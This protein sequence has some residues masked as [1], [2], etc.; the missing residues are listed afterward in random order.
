MQ[1]ANQ[2]FT[3]KTQVKLQSPIY[4]KRTALVSQIPNFWKLVLE[5]A[6][7]DIDQFIQPSDSACLAACLKSITVRNYEIDPVEVPGGDARSLEIAFEFE[8]NEYF[9]DSKIVKKFA[10]RRWRDGMV[11]FTSEPVKINWKAGKDLTHGLLD[12][13]VAAYQSGYWKNPTDKDTPHATEK[14]LLDKINS[15]GGSGSFFNFFGF[16]GRRL[17][18]AERKL[19]NEEEAKRAKGEDIPYVETEDETREEIEAECEIFPDGDDLAI[20]FAEDLWP[21]A[22]KYFTQTQQGGE[23]EDDEEL[24]EI[25]GDEDGI[26]EMDEDESEEEKPKSK[27]QKTNGKN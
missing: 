3:V 12:A 16:V 22:L 26:E 2:A 15:E 10:H 25:S 11:G 18:E 14:A 23:W 17:T 5:S 27:K 4:T 7:Q 20:A 9:T 1:Q 19:A 24:S 6:P 21:E 8:E 13:A